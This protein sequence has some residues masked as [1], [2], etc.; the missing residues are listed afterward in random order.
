LDYTKIKKLA[1]PEGF[2]GEGEEIPDD[3]DEENGK[4]TRNELIYI[5]GRVYREDFNSKN[6]QAHDKPK[7]IYEKWN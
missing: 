6:R 1:L 3:E 2:E 5:A 4:K 7:W